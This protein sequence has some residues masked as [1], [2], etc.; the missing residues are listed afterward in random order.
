MKSR[1]YSLCR[2]CLDKWGVLWAHSQA[3]S[4]PVGALR[5]PCECHAHHQTAPFSDRNTARPC[6]LIAVMSIALTRPA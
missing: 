6:A 2:A 3:S 4:K 5:A 1:V